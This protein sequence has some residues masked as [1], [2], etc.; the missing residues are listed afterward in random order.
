MPLGEAGCKLENG[1]AAK[2]PPK[3][4]QVRPVTERKPEISYSLCLENCSGPR[5]KHAVV[6]K[7]FIKLNN[8]IFKKAN[9]GASITTI[10]LRVTSRIKVIKKA[11]L[12]KI[13]IVM[14]AFPYKCLYLV[15][16]LPI[17]SKIAKAN[18]NNKLDHSYEMPLILFI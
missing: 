8:A 14:H 5:I 2:V 1:R 11:N 9:Q 18:E 3:I 10:S 6:A 12:S 16:Y 15:I 7:P 4:P 17:V 13:K